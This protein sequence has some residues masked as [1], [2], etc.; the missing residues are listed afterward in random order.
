MPRNSWPQAHGFATFNADCEE[1]GYFLGPGYDSLSSWKSNVKDQNS[2][3]CVVCKVCNHSC[4]VKVDNFHRRKKAGCFCTGTVRWNT[5]AGH[6]RMLSLISNSRF[7]LMPHLQTLE[8]WLSEHRDNRSKLALRCTK[9]GAESTRCWINTFMLNRTADCNC[10]N[11]TQTEVEQ[12]VRTVCSE[13]FPQ[14]TVDRE[15]PCKGRMRLDIAL[16]V[17]NKAILVVEID[18]EQHFRCNTGFRMDFIAV[19][20]R[21]LL[22]D[23]WC[24]ENGIPMLRLRQESIQKRLFDWKNVLLKF[25]GRAHQNELQPLVYRQNHKVYLTGS[26]A[27][28]RKCS[29][30]HVQID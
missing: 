6:D 11:K 27:E 29:N 7:E 2:K 16:Y 17:N 4:D 28:M 15:V 20:K 23:F 10:R 13:S 24:V 8:G 18:G 12:F 9:C 21:D 22:K 25:I 1:G 26:Y 5:K 30:V 14:T 3:V 19:Q